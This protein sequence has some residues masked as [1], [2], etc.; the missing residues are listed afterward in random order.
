MVAGNKEYFAPDVVNF[1]IRKDL[2]LHR[3]PERNIAQ[4]DNNF[5]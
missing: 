2:E 1:D 5:E 4:V 3:G